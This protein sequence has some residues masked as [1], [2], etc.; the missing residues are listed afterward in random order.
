M[1]SFSGNSSH[2]KIKIISGKNTNRLNKVAIAEVSLRASPKN[3]F[4]GNLIFLKLKNYSNKL[5]VKLKTCSY[6]HF[7][8][9]GFQSIRDILKQR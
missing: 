6:H 1:I 5:V 7:R 8:M 2:S 9:E 3:H 4:L